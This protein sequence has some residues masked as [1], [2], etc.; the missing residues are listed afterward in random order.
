MTHPTTVEPRPAGDG[1]PELTAWEPWRIRQGE[2]REAIRGETN[3]TEA[4]VADLLRELE[5]HAYEVWERRRRRGATADEAWEVVVADLGDARDFARALVPATP[6]WKGE[7]M[8]RTLWTGIAAAACVAGGLGFWPTPAPEAIVRVAMAQA[9]EAKEKQQEPLTE[10]EVAK[11][12]NAVIDFDF[13]QAPL[14]DVLQF[15]GQSVD[16]QFVPR[17]RSLE[18]EGITLELPIS[19]N[20]RRVRVSTVLRLLEDDFALK[21]VSQDGL[22]FV[23]TPNDPQLARRE[24]TIQ[25]YNCRD[26]LRLA[27]VGEP[28]GANPFESAT[29]ESGTSSLQD[30]LMSVGDGERWE[31]NGGTWTIREFNGLVT[32]RT[33]PEMHEKIS[34]LL[35]MLRESAADELDP[36]PPAG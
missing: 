35:K 16:L 26:L 36:K 29:Q 33:T 11:R 12:L 28:A 2:L 32:I 30:V 5:S 7:I 24:M 17:K 31:L 14:A 19:L 1:I 9:P 22:M 13:D 3:L 20:L 4:E 21:F 8:Q 27:R 18:G 23:T 34:A 10:P 15:L 25:V 6:W